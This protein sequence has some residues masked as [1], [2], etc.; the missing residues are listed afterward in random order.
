MDC[1]F[2]QHPQVLFLGHGETLLWISFCLAHGISNIGLPQNFEVRVL[3]QPRAKLMFLEEKVPVILVFPPDVLIIHL[4]MFDLLQVE[5][6]PLAMADRL[7]LLLSGLSMTW[8]VI[9]CWSHNPWHV[10]PDHM[11]RKHLEAFHSR[12]VHIA[13]GSRNFFHFAPGCS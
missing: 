13:G 5:A 4:G 10:V 7:G 8:V 9:V 6:D 11:Y 3:S 1:N 12:L 2:F